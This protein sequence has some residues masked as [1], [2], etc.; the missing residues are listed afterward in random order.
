MRA[1]IGEGG[2]LVTVAGPFD[3]IMGAAQLRA[4]FVGGV[5][6]PQ[7]WIERMRDDSD[8]AR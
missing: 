7:R 8:L 2:K 1:G 6:V 5:A 3:A 4:S